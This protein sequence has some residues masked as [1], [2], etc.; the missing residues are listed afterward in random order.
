MDSSR[1]LLVKGAAWIASA[2][3]IINLIALASTIILARLLLPEDFGLV[4]IAESIAIMAASITELSLVQALIQHDDPEE[5][6]YHTAFTL[7]LIRAVLLALFL[8][9]ISFPVAAAY[10]DPRLGPILFVIAGSTVIGALENPKLITFQ[11]KLVF[12]QE[13]SL[14]VGT[15]LAAFVTA[16]TIAL[17]Y[18]S[19]WALILGGVAGQTARVLISYLVV[20]YRPR[21]CFTEWR[22]LV[23]FS[24]WLTFGQAIRSINMRSVPLALG[25]V[26]SP[27][28]LG[29][30]SLGVRL[31]GMAVNESIGPLRQTLFPAFSRMKDDRGRLQAAYIRAQ[32]FL[33]SLA[34]PV[35]VGFALLAE[36]LIGLLIGEKWLPAVPIIQVLTIIAAL[37]VLESSTPLGMAVGRTKALFRR[38]L[39]VFIIRIP[40]ILAGGLIGHA[41]SLGIIMGVVFGRSLSSIVNLIWNMQLVKDSTDLS[42]KNQFAV[43]ARPAIAAAFM[44]AAL[45]Y[46]EYENLIDVEGLNQTFALFGLIIVGGVTYTITLLCAWIIQG[47]PSGPEKDVSQF[48]AS[49]AKRWV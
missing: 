10:G 19:Y 42:L 44:S 47:R 1:K 7:N 16:I 39:R 48:V 40:L 35:S 27:A 36:P 32:A 43:F 18:Q 34:F 29:H 41:T 13:A 24:G 9:G 38:D 14:S 22:D 49:L 21:I 17:V 4:A 20:H 31:A 45:S 23:S 3:I 2:R 46:I 25:F 5:R 28:S 6:H 33:C 15:K 26:I 12:L 37:E 11:R 30:Y 8:C